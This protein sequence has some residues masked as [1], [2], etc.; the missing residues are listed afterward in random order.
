MKNRFL[1][2]II[3]FAL[4]G[5]GCAHTQKTTTTETTTQ[6]P[7]SGAI[8]SVP[9]A[10]HTTVVKENTTT[11]TTPAANTEHTGILGGIAHIIVAIVSFPF[12]VIGGLF[13][14]IF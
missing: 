10:Q 2:L 3:V 1:G 9:E 14:M 6:Y 7:S 4:F 8:G 5:F 12:V 13:R 11:T